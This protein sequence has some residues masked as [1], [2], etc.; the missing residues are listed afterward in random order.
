VLTRRHPRVT[1]DVTVGDTDMLVRKLRERA[2]DVV[3]TRWSRRT[4]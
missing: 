4:P 1:Y 3:L 2:L